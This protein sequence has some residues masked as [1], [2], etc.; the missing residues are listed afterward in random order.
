MVAGAADTSPVAESD[1][2]GAEG[3]I[4]AAVIVLLGAAVLTGGQRDT[5][6]SRAH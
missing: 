2:L 3:Y 5:A 1:R 6:L 4:V